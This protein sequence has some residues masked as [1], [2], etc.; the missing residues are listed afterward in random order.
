PMKL[1]SIGRSPQVALTPPPTVTCEM[2]ATLTRWMEREVQ[3]LARK[4]L[5]GPIVRIATMSSYSCRNAYGRVHGRV[6]EHG[7]ANAVDIGSFIT[8]R[9]Q[10]ALVVADWGPTARQ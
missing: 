2:V 1:I 3:P 9:G 4:D 10:A 6:S 8:A 7:K 5:G